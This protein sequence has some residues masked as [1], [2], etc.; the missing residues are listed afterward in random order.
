MAEIS[1]QMIRNDWIATFHQRYPE[2]TLIMATKYLTSEHLP[3]VVTAGIKHIGENRVE[4]LLEKKAAHPNLLLQ[5]HFIGTLQSKKVKKVIQ[6]IDVLH[7]LDRMSLALEIE[8]HRREVLPCFIQVNISQEPQKH[9]LD[10]SE[11]EAFL[12]E[13]V[14]FSSIEVIGLMGMAEDTDQQDVI[15]E[16]FHRL[17]ALRDTL[18]LKY[19]SCQNLSMGMS[20]DY[21]L[22]LACGATHVRLGRLLLNQEN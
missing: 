21:A 8:K 17:K 5:W 20:N 1:V 13:L 7:T 3:D 9:G 22:A 15:E 19:P 11:V 2:A 14:S 10:S 6:H 16:Q 4:S 18:S 12:R